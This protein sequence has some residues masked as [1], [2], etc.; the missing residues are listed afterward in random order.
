MRRLWTRRWILVHLGTV[1][2][3]TGFLL[4]GWWQINR[5]RAGNSLSFG[6]AAEWPAF[7]AFVIYVWLKEVRSVLRSD[8][9]SDRK[10]ASPPAIREVIRASRT[11]RSEAAYDDTDDADLTAYNHYLAWLSANP[12]ASPAQYP[13]RR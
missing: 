6:Y 9:K 13:G 12:N 11:Q 1:V 4:L 5:A 3:V 2:L 10:E 8:R 7:A